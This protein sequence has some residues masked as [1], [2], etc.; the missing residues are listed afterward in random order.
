MR[1]NAR[2]V[3]RCRAELGTACGPPVQNL[4]TDSVWA[5]LKITTVTLSPLEHTHTHKAFVTR[6]HACV[7][8]YLARS[9]F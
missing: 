3:A 2:H 9:A 5:L 7:S 6:V 8:V 4:H 1:S